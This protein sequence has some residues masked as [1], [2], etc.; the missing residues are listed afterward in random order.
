MPRLKNTP[1]GYSH[2]KASGQA[3]VRLNSREHYLGRYGYKTLFFYGGDRDFEDM[4]GFFLKNGFERFYDCKDY[5]GIRYKNPIGVYDEE[6]FENADRVFS[7]EKEPFFAVMM[8]LTNHGP[9]TLPPDYNDFPP[10]LRADQ[11]DKLG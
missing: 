7:R 10:G 1:P 4:G 3:Y 6:M 8:T 9:F 11:K 5:T 2:H